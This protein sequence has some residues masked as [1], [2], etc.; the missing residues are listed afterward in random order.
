MGARMLRE[1]KITAEDALRQTAAEN[2]DGL[3]RPSAQE[4]YRESQGEARASVEM[5]AYAI[6]VAFA[7][8]L[9]GAV[10]L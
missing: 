8:T 7:A 9:V 5:L 1:K 6:L 10:I 2:V 4:M 3:G